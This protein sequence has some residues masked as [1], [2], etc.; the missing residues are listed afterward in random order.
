MMAAAGVFSCSRRR[1][2][3]ASA[4]G[5]A[6][7]SPPLVDAVEQRLAPEEIVRRFALAELADFF[8]RNGAE[9]LI[10]GCTHFP[11]FRQ[12]LEQCT[13]LPLIDPADRM[14]ERLVEMLG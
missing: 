6:I 2:S 9:C 10:L 11:Y 7:S 8:R 4:S 13:D 12:A 3:S 14:Y 5:T 1:H